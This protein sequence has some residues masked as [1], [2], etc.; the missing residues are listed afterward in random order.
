MKSI[1]PILLLILFLSF[2]FSKANGQVNNVTTPIPASPTYSGLAEQAQ[3]NVSLYNGK[4]G[5]S[6]PLGTISYFEFNI[7]VSLSYNGG[8]LRVDQLAGIV[9]TN[10]NLNCGGQIVRTVRGKDDFDAFMETGPYAPTTSRGFFDPINSQT[11]NY[12]LA[13]G[14]TIYSPAVGG[15]PGDDNIDIDKFN[16]FQDGA[17]DIEPDIYSYSFPGHSGSF[18]FTPTGKI[19]EIVRSGL[20][21]EYNSASFGGYFLI[22]DE[23]G[24]QYTFLTNETTEAKIY[25]ISYGF[26]YSDFYDPNQSYRRFQK[27]TST[28]TLSKITSSTSERELKFQY[29]AD[30]SIPQDLVWSSKTETYPPDAIN[31]GC[32]D[33]IEPLTSGRTRSTNKGKHLT[34]IKTENDIELLTCT[35]TSVLGN[36]CM[37]DVNHTA[38]NA[39]VIND[40]RLDELQINSAAGILEVKNTFTYKSPLESTD[41]NYENMFRIGK[42]FLK[43]VKQNCGG[44]EDYI[45][46]LGYN[47][48][49][50]KISYING[51]NVDA[52]GFNS[53]TDNYTTNR[54]NS[55]NHFSDLAASLVGSLQF[56]EYPNHGISK[57]TYELHGSPGSTESEYGGLRIKRIDYFRSN[58]LALSGEGLTREFHYQSPQFLGLLKPSR[59][60]VARIFSL[61]N[62][63]P[64]NEC[65]YQVTSN[66]T[67]FNVTG[68]AQGN[69]IAYSKVEVVYSV[70]GG[71]LT[72]KKVY[73]YKSDF[74]NINRLEL[75]CDESLPYISSGTNGDVYNG[76]FAPNTTY[77]Y[78][79]GT[80]LSEEEYTYDA[81]TA[82]YEVNPINKTEYTYSFTEDDEEDESFGYKTYGSPGDP[83]AAYY[84]DLETASLTRYKIR[85]GS[86]RLDKIT[87]TRYVNNTPFVTVSDFTYDNISITSRNVLFGNHTV[88]MVKSFPI[89]R[90]ETITHQD[91]TRFFNKYYYSG[92]NFGQNA[93][94]IPNNYKTAIAN[95]NTV[96]NMQTTPLVSHSG[97][98]ESAPEGDKY[99]VTASS[100]FLPT[101]SQ[102]KFLIKQQYEL[103]SD[104]PR[105]LPFQP[106]TLTNTNQF[107][108]P[109]NFYRHK[110]ETTSTMFNLPVETL[111]EDI[112]HVSL[113]HSEDGHAAE[114]YLKG[115]NV[116]LQDIAFT[117]FEKSQY[118][119]GVIQYGWNFSNSAIIEGEDEF[120]SFPQRG[121][122]GQNYLKISQTQTI[123]KNSISKRSFLTFWV[124]SG[125]RIEVICTTNDGVTV[126]PELES[127]VSRHGFT[128]YH[129]IIDV[130]SSILIK[131]LFDEQIA[132][133]EV[134]LYPVD[135][136]LTTFFYKKGFYGVSG[137]CDDND[138][139]SYL[140]VKE[141][142]SENSV[143]GEPEIE[144]VLI[145]RNDK[146]QIIEVEIYKTAEPQ[147]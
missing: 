9:G 85:S 64:H 128:L 127:H 60:T 71:A 126:Y 3:D 19:V 12:T 90:M 112:Y 68:S 51:A 61:N 38:T 34:S 142:I 48:G 15:S 91:Q 79:N 124:E 80:L 84:V 58:G 89:K 101:V 47:Q 54:A 104:V 27:Y 137:S 132:I 88:N 95:M 107:Y 20:K 70:T 113:R 145:H 1:F 136:H 147:F 121:V 83:Q 21:I 131:S 11:P 44:N 28:W 116:Q 49:N 31:I 93:V 32:Y 81:S 130:S 122:T 109:L 138:I 139:V 18:V 99:L 115:D 86:V 67:L 41:A 2:P 52:F 118:G 129:A 106:F 4:L 59:M 120:A 37:N 100:F 17:L 114:L 82:S 78:S 98:I 125:K 111:V 50:G 73:R 56:I 123:S 16:N 23:Q 69:G 42:Y 55:Q 94:T 46:N 36:A 10:W 133:D 117:S 25:P 74:D 65:Y 62:S 110:S 76:Y 57:F 119:D 75:S 140:E 40:Y 135:G 22:T 7:P 43:S 105:L 96:W 102:S 141:R 53:S 108:T 92:D 87:R 72:G 146:G 14:L 63:I 6:I 39:I 143:N 33:Y 13:N 5:V 30:Y 8:G 45:Y 77:E 29:T 26:A 24:F 134:R 66:S 97:Y 144:D 35:L 103:K